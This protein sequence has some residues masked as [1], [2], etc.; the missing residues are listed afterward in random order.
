MSISFNIFPW[1]VTRGKFH[2]Y[3]VSIGSTRLFPN[4]AP[5]LAPRTRL[6]VHITSFISNQAFNPFV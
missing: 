1:K 6:L 2:Y 5:L 3:I 4:Q